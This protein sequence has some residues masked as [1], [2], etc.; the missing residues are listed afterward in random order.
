MGLYLPSKYTQRFI[1]SYMVLE[2]ER[3][4]TINDSINT[5]YLHLYVVSASTSRFR[6]LFLVPASAPR[7]G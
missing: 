5:F 6:E 4:K 7:L 2:Q 3:L 1:Y